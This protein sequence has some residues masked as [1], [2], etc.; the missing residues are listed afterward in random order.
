MKYL[1]IYQQL[2]TDILTN[3]YNE[4]T[5]LPS[6][7]ILA[8]T[9]ECSI[10]TIQQVMALLVEDNLIYAKNRSGYYIIQTDKLVTPLIDDHIDFSAQHLSWANFPY[11]DFQSCLKQAVHNYQK[12]LF[13]YGSSQG[14]P[15]LITTLTKWLAGRHIYT[16]EDSVFITTGTQQALFILSQL[17]FPNRKATILIES[18][19]YHLMLS[20][21]S[22]QSHPFITI[23]RDASELDFEQLETIFRENEIKFFYTTSRLSNP[24]GLSYSENEKKQLVALAKKYD[25]YIIEDDYL[26]DYV[27]ET[28]NLPLHYYD[29]DN[30][31]IYLKSF[32]KIMFPGLRIGACLLPEKLVACF[33]AYRSL[34]EIDSAIFSQAALDIYI[35][36]QMFD[37]HI[38]HLKKLLVQKNNAFKQTVLAQPNQSVIPIQ[39]FTSAKTFLQLPK[40]LPNSLFLKKLAAENIKLA[41][42][43]RHYLPNKV[44]NR[45]I[46]GIEL[47]NVT[48]QQIT[49]GLSKIL[50]LVTTY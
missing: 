13:I 22:I 3:N 42:L 41:S 12:D 35:K 21:L 49:Q 6:L 44:P 10:Q 48:P 29:T 36:S 17:T 25:V 47:F 40:D 8:K 32:S 19:S 4:G 38:N 43:N 34:M 20:L 14:L 39:Q 7:R 27:I 30:R 45:A 5:K 46:Y 11:A 1:T 9:Y 37:A 26:A 2:K 50:S 28:N 15:A 23:N 31:V 16:N 18:P 24:L 33:Q